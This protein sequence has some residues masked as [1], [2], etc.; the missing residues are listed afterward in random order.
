[1]MILSF[2]MEINKLRIVICQEL[3]QIYS[4]SSLS[5]FFTISAKGVNF[6]KLTIFKKRRKK[7][8]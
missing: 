7:E 1:M 6:F 2:Y 8:L 5:F 3:W 4:A